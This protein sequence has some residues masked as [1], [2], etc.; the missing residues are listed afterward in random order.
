MY[1]G[2]NPSGHPGT[3]QIN[4]I[5]NSLY[6]RYCFVVLGEEHGFTIKDF[7]KHV[8]LITYGDDNVMG[9]SDDV[10]WFNH[11]SIAATLADVGITYTMADKEA[12][13]VPYI[14]IDEVS[15]LKRKWVWEEDLGDF[16]C[17]LD[18]NSIHKMLMYRT[19]G[20]DTEEQQLANQIRS[21]HGEFFYHGREVFKEHDQFL[22]DLLVEFELHEYVDPDS[23][24]TWD[25]YVARWRAVRSTGV[26]SASGESH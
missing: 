5:V 26:P 4:S 18:I 1:H 15:F 23:L 3:V 10:P 22:R 25:E 13:S 9:V 8:A 19:M 16:A 24:P 20:N 11:T 6:M 7:R 12:E 2:S 21:A 17:P 14:T